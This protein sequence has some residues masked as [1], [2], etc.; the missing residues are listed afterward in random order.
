MYHR[1]F[2][3]TAR[4]GC[5]PL[6]AGRFLIRAWLYTS[7]EA[8]GCG[9]NVDGVPLVD[10]RIIFN[11]QS[12]QWPNRAC[13]KSASNCLYFGLNCGEEDLGV[14]TD[15]G[16]IDGPTGGGPRRVALTFWLID[17][18]LGGINQSYCRNQEILHRHLLLLAYENTHVDQLAPQCVK[19]TYLC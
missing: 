9:Q 15:M 5:F 17:G 3:V 2:S 4:E 19:T 8:K 16:G 18:G 11:C 10:I 14:G 1:C 7:Y 6:V 13:H 12:L